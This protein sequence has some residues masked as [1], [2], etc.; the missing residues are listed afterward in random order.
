MRFIPDICALAI[1]IYTTYRYIHAGIA[2]IYRR[3][4]FRIIANIANGTTVPQFNRWCSVYSVFAWNLTP[5]FVVGIVADIPLPEQWYSGQYVLGTH[6]L[7]LLGQAELADRDCRVFITMVLATLY[8]ANVRADLLSQCR[9]VH[10]YWRAA[11][12]RAWWLW[13]VVHIYE[14]CERRAYPFR[15]LSPAAIGYYVLFVHG[16]MHWAGGVYNLTRV[17]RACVKIFR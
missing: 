16:T 15:K 10:E 7:R 12:D 6:H 14:R 11:I 5:A 17:I 3:L 9:V 1:L 8:A 13:P 2:S 4:M